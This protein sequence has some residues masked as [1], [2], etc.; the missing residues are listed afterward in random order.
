M[1]IP[2]PALSLWPSSKA[3]VCKT[4]KRGCNSHQA[5]MVKNVR[6][7]ERNNIIVNDSINW[8]AMHI[9]YAVFV[10][11]ASKQKILEEYPTTPVD[12]LMN[13]YV[14]EAKEKLG[15]CIDDYVACHNARGK[16]PFHCRP[17]EA[18][19]SKSLQQTNYAVNKIKKLLSGN[20]F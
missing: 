15:S 11:D 18:Y 13:M 19:W 4:Q 1:R 5:L 9:L 12:E 3:C 17:R 6:V 2:S 16:A 14:A 20:R 7:D 10:R 8:D